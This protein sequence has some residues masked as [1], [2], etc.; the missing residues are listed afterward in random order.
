MT[1]SSRG[2]VVSA[3][4]LLAGLAPLLWL[5]GRGSLGGS[6]WLDEVTYL[7]YAE[8]PEVRERAPG[9]AVSG[10]ESAL[11]GM[12]A[13]PNL[14]RPYRALT[15]PLW[16]RA[17]E[18][19]LRLPSLLAV[20]ALACMAFF[21]AR[22]RGLLPAL[23]A[24]LAV[25]ALPL[26]GFYAF[27][28]RV[29]AITALAAAGFV[30]LAARWLEEGGRA[31]WLAVAALGTLLPWLSIWAAPLVASCAAW[32]LV[33]IWR[34][35]RRR[36]TR[37]LLATGPG[38]AM[39]FL[40]LYFL[41]ARFPHQSALRFSRSAGPLES[42]G[43]IGRGLWEGPSGFPPD[44]PPWGTSI[45][46]FLALAALVALLALG[47]RSESREGR[48]AGIVVLALP[49]LL[50]AASLVP[51]FVPGRYD[52]PWVGAAFVALATSPGRLRQ[53][54]LAGIAVLGLS[55][56]PWTETRIAKKGNGRQ[57]VEAIRSHESSD[58]E[59]IAVWDHLGWDPLLRYPVHFY[60]EVQG[61]ERWEGIH[62]PSMRPLG[63]DFM[64]FDTVV[65][66]E[67]SRRLQAARRSAGLPS[68][69]EARGIEGLWIV[70]PESA[71]HRHRE[72]LAPVLVGSGFRQVR[73]WRVT[74][75]PVTRLEHWRRP[76]PSS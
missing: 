18:P 64:L 56:L 35:N 62:L 1:K 17:P 8:R 2:R 34:G 50:L 7:T 49:G 69:A 57:I 41:L 37:L 12:F 43:N 46:L 45:G 52:V 25:S 23:L 21:V 31:G 55:V 47:F 10:V 22:P 63:D 60:A 33:E 20:A 19:M 44:A 24:T 67:R 58:R 74:G 70:V 4:A 28:G 5:A 16:Q 42:L 51:G 9:V 73:A 54:I 27:E 68:W 59:A 48:A 14:I 72:V 29:Y 40:Q 11:F 39:A 30:V 76:H 13:Y 38:G 15:G 3:V 6:F 26:L 53:A 61:K 36:G 32:S 65:D 75:R 71:L 66:S